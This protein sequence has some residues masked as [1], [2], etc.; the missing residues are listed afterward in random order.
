MNRLWNARLPASDLLCLTRW[1][2]IP[3]IFLCMTCFCSLLWLT[4]T[5]LC[6]EIMFSSPIHL[7]ASVWTESMKG[8]WKYCHSQP[9]APVSLTHA[10]FVP[11][12]AAARAHARLT[13]S[14][15]TLHTGSL[16]SDTSFHFY[17][18]HARALFPSHCH[19]HC[20]CFVLLM[21][22][23]LTEVKRKYKVVL[24]WFGLIFFPINVVWPTYLQ[25]PNILNTLVWCGVV[26]F[27]RQDFSL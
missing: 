1:P 20:V 8:C 9:D 4:K 16:S 15:L 25:W 18:G 27:S 14:S 23:I 22:G 12:S 3:S 19:K 5:P 13:F 7:P 11:R 2:R 21:A 6:I 17:Q 26:W 24:V 10:D